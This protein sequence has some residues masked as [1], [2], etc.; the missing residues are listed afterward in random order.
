MAATRCMQY[1]LVDLE[2]AG[3]ETTW[4]PTVEIVATMASL[5][6]RKM[7]LMESFASCHVGLREHVGAL[8]TR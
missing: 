4:T 3:G 5:A 7:A 2:T 6:L 8:R 1:G